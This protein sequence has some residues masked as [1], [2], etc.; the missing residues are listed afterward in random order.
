MIMNLTRPLVCFDIE[1]TGLDVATAKIIQIHFYKI[2]PGNPGDGE[3]VPSSLTCLINPCMSIPPES[4][5][6]HH[7]T[8]DM[9][10]DLPD[11]TA[12]SQRIH[13]FVKDCDLVGYNL[14]NYDIPLLWEELY[15]CGI[16]WDISKVHVID[17]GA[18]FKIKEQRTLSAALKFYCGR[19]MEN[20]HDA[21]ADVTATMAVLE[22]QRRRYPDLATMSVPELA[23]FSKQDKRVD[24][25]GKIVLDKDGDPSYAIGNAKGQKVRDNRSFAHWMLSKDFTSETKATLCRILDEIDNQGQREIF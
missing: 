3:M 14:R 10:K 25:A 9:V 4:T 5:E 2:T 1:G 13:D 19:E 8:D 12:F 6:V 16:K 17:A 20:A 15:R 22:G 24:L 7:I 23:E 18:I 21:G 11:F